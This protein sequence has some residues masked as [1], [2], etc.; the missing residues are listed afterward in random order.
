MWAGFDEKDRGLDL[1][2]EEMKLFGGKLGIGARPSRTASQGR[3]QGRHLPTSA[4]SRSGAVVASRATDGG[5]AMERWGVYR[6][7]GAIVS[8]VNCLLQTPILEMPMLHLILDPQ[9]ATASLP[10]EVRERSAG[11]R[12]ARGAGIFQRG[13]TM[14]RRPT[15]LRS[16][17]RETA[18]VL[19]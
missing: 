15:T 8:R 3:E 13:F 14:L 16:T 17:T 9:P 4:V 12:W 6:K 5:Y 1:P 10:L 7:H 11:P 2:L 19:Q 18:L